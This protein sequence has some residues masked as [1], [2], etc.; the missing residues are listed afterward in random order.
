MQKCPLQPTTLRS[1][2]V[3]FWFTPEPWHVCMLLLGD[4]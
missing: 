2:E 4:L 3:A 1:A